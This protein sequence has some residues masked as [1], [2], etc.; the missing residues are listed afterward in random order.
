MAKIVYL[1]V[2]FLVVAHMMVKPG[3]SLKCSDTTTMASLCSP[4][5]KGQQPDP[6]S[7]CCTAVKEIRE[8]TNTTET[9]RQ[10]CNCVQQN[11]KRIPGALLTRFDDLPL[12]CGL[13][14]IY[15]AQPT[16]DCNSVN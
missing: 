3:E 8:S 1:M 16:F 2:V 15:S 12:K 4:Y 14:V 11:A 10:L 7:E 13:P 9:R 5:T 6:Y